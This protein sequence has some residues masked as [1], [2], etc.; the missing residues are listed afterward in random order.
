[1]TDVDEKLPVW[2]SWLKWLGQSNQQKKDK[3]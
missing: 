2:N 1:M 3:R